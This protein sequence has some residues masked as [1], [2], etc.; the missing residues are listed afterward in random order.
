MTR[1]TA[2]IVSAAFFTS[3]ALA[4]DTPLLN[5]NNP[6]GIADAILNLG[7]K[8]SL[9][10]DNEGDPKIRSAASGANF[11]I[12]FYGCRDGKD[13]RDLHFSSGFD[14]D[15]EGAPSVQQL[16]DWNRD[17]LVGVAYQEADDDIL[18]QFFV[19]GFR[20]VSAESFER[21]FSRWETALGDF[22]DYIDW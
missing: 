8:A 13:C 16:H 10:T 15:G 12:Y 2:A 6:Q 21:I 22:T 14:F 19:A 17:K 7:Y 9:T 5:A 3:P 1:L 20:D 11:S 4:Q 18:I